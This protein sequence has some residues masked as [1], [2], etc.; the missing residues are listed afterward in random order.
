MERWKIELAGINNLTVE[1]GVPRFFSFDNGL[2]GPRRSAEGAGCGF[3]RRIPG[4]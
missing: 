1:T 3:W 2:L 4:K